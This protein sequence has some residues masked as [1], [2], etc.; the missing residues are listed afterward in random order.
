[1]QWQCAMLFK[2]QVFLCW[3]KVGWNFPAHYRAWLVDRGYTNNPPS[4]LS[5][6]TGSSQV[7]G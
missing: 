6:G 3:E 7:F 1:M 2:R 5:P 4:W